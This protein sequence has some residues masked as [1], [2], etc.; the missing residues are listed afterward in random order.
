MGSAA[1]LSGDTQIDIDKAKEI[2]GDAWTPELEARF[3]SAVEEK[4]PFTLDDAR[5]LAP[6]LFGEEMVGLEK[7]K[8]LA[9]ASGVEW[10]DE[11]NNIFEANVDKEKGEIPLSKWKSLVPTLF[12]TPEERKQR[13]DAEFRALLAAKSEGNVV[14]NY[15]M[16]NEEFPISENTLTAARIDEDYGLTDVMPGCRIRLSTI[17]SKART[18]YENANN[19]E[20]PWVKE[21]PE[22]TF[23]ELLAGEKYFCIVIENPEQYAKDMEALR[24]RLEAEG[25]APVESSGR[26]E[27]C[28]CLYGNPCM[29]QYICKDWDNRYAVAKAN[30]WKGF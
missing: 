22:G 15:Q 13:L 25:G 18:T 24:V 23:R 8:E 11:L 12:E 2:A 5:K 26:A 29:D 10:N 30:G 4:S 28:S 27:G 20:A 1:S 6:E 14:V 17:D 3:K 21:D 7:V 9:L 16:Y 19:C